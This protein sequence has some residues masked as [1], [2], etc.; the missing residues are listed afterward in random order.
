M[1]LYGNAL[2]RRGRAV[3]SFFGTV[4]N[5][6]ALGREFNLSHKLKSGCKFE[7]RRVWHIISAFALALMLTKIAH[8]SGTDLLSSQN[9]TVNATFGSDS[10]IVKWFYIGEIVIALFTYIKVRSPLVFLGLVLCI[11]FTRIGFAIAS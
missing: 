6:F 11:I 4:R 1:S 10:S 2:A 8:A 9:T 5:K 7:L 3:A